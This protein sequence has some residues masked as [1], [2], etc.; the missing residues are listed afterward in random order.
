MAEFAV[1]RDNQ[2]AEKWD[3]LPKAWE[4]VSGLHLLKDDEETL[5]SLGIYTVQKVYV[6]C[7]QNTQYIESY[8]YSFTDNKV[9][10]RAVVKNYP[11]STVTPEEIFNAALAAVRIERDSR[12]S[13][14][15]WTQL[16][17]VQSIHDEEWKTNWATYRQAL[18]DLPNQC[19]SGEINIYDIIWPIEPN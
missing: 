18:R 15:D 13:K 17:D 3:N 9:Y 1:V 8:D 2:V 4:H 19:I 14:C 10:E 6:H 11:P 12:I 7:D 5:N 16:A